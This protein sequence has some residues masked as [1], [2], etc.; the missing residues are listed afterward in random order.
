MATGYKQRL[1]AAFAVVLTSDMALAAEEPSMT[2]SAVVARLEKEVAKEAPSYKL[3]PT[4]KELGESKIPQYEDL[5]QW[6][7]G[8]EHFEAS[9]RCGWKADN[10]D[11]I[12]ACVVWDATSLEPD[13]TGAGLI[14]ALDRSFF[15]AAFPGKTL[16]IER[17]TGEASERL[18]EDLRL[19]GFSYASGSSSVQPIAGWEAYISR[20]WTNGTQAPPRRDGPVFTKCYGI[21][22]S[23]R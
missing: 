18:T 22:S 3:F 6:G 8:E 9:L 21:S 20:G 17:M 4:Q 14:A 16:D 5:L 12:D 2:C 13:S 15:Q 10:I 1:V 23:D 11:F 19:H 7:T